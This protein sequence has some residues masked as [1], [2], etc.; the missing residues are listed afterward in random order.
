MQLEA[1]DRRAVMQHAAR[2]GAQQIGDEVEDRALAR[3]VGADQADHRSGGDFERAA[4]DRQK[5]AEPLGKAAHN[6]PRR[7]R[8]PGDQGRPRAIAYFF[9]QAQGGTGL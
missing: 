3:A 5:T 9:S 7:G 4:I 2:I 8:V 6:Q 1:A